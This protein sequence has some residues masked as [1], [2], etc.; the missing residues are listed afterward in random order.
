[1]V[2]KLGFGC[3]RLPHVDGVV[4][5]E[6][7]KKMVDTYLER[8]FTYFDTAWMYCNGKSEEIMR[9]ALVERH[10]M[11]SSTSLCRAASAMAAM[12]LYPSAS[13]YISS[14]WDSIRS[15]RLNSVLPSMSDLPTYSF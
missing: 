7:T 3:M 10:P 6:L 15:D 11:R 4:D 1:M 9:E 13:G 2:K 8:G 12:I 5:M 14:E